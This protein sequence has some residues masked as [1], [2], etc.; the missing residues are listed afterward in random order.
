M[1]NYRKIKMV[2]ECDCSYSNESHRRYLAHTA[3][4]SKFKKNKNLFLESKKEEIEELYKS[5][6]VLSIVDSIG[7]SPYVSHSSITKI[8]KKWGHVIRGI[9]ETKMLSSVKERTAK[10]CMERYGGTGNPLSI[11]SSLKVKRDATVS[12]KHGVSNIFA[13]KWFADNVTYNENFWLDRHGYSRQEMV[14]KAGKTL[15]RTY[16]EQE[17]KQRIDCANKSRIHTKSSTVSKLELETLSVL[18]NLYDIEPQKWISNENGVHRSF[19]AKLSNTSILIEINGDYWH[20]NPSIYTVGDLISYPGGPIKVEELWDRDQFKRDLAE[21]HG[22]KLI[23]FWES[24][25]RSATN[26][27]QLLIDRIE[28]ENC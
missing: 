19:D 27:A 20:A 8:L 12:E 10:T 24:E 13:S 15:W 9:S 11:G 4:C 22:Y 5:S 17:R 23:T 6:S 21:S 3:R 18:A 25:I 28:N 7:E 1:G 14:S 2:Y 26:L 16:S